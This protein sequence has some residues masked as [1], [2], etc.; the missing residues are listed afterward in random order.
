NHDQ[1]RVVSRIGSGQARI[2]AMMLLTLR[3]TP[4]MYYGDEI[5]MH[6]VEIPEDRIQDPQAKNLGSRLGR[7]PQ[8]TPM[9]WDDSPGAGFSEAD[10]WLPIADDFR[11]IN[12]AAQREDPGSLLSLYRKLIGLRSEEA[13]LAV[14]DYEPVELGSDLLAYVR[15]Q[16]D[17]RWLVVLNFAAEAVSVPLPDQKGEVCVSTHLD[18]EGDRIVDVAALRPDEGILVL[19]D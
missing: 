13:A 15:S 9:Q 4:T 2:A 1:P 17:R 5:G 11:E 18:R 10:P 12:V 3:G 19:L 16:G 8:R 6:D 14:G 7:D